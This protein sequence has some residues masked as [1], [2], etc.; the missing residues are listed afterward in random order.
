MYV[1]MY[2]QSPTLSVIIYVYMY[3]IYL[4]SRVSMY[5]NIYYSYVRNTDVHI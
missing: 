1:V 3:Y 5:V 2:K 4:Y